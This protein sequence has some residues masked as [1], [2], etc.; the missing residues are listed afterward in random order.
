VGQILKYQEILFLSNDLLW[1]FYFPSNFSR[2]DVCFMFQAL[3][4]KP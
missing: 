3:V 4:V 1:I 2:L